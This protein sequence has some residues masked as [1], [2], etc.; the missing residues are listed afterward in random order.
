MLV[1]VKNVYVNVIKHVGGGAF[2][3]FRVGMGLTN[4]VLVPLSGY[5][6]IE[7]KAMKSITNISKISI[8]LFLFLKTP[9]HNSTVIRHLKR[10]IIGR[11]SFK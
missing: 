1:R 3:L 10:L 11:Q 4:C 9:P 7:N 5:K 8:L 2:H 6:K